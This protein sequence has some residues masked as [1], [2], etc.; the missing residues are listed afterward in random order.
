M[1]VMPNR[2]PMEVI[3]NR[4][5]MDV[6]PN[7]QPMDVI[8]NRQPMDVIPNRARP[9][10]EPAFC[11][12][13]RAPR[14]LPAEGHFPSEAEGISAPPHSIKAKAL[15][16]NAFHIPRASKPEPCQKY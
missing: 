2:Q 9:G 16:R 4:Q 14:L 8:P 12:S 7:R 10:E 3:P 1:D 6:I 13:S 15:P 5:P 11:S